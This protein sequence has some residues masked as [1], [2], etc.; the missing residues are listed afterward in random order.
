MHQSSDRWSRRRLL[1]S[2]AAGA[3]TLTHGRL[4][5]GAARPAPRLIGGL[6]SSVS[7]PG[8]AVAQRACHL[9]TPQIDTD[10]DWMP[11]T[12]ALVTAQEGNAL[13]F[14]LM[15]TPEREADWHWLAPLLVDRFVLVLAPG[16]Q[17]HGPLR[18]GALRGSFIGERLAE[19]GYLQV[20]FT[21]SEAVNARKLGLG[22][23][24][25]WATM[26]GVALAPPHLASLPAGFTLH[27]LALRPL[28][29]WLVASRDVAMAGLPHPGH[30]ALA[31][32]ESPAELPYRQL[33]T[34]ARS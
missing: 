8:S 22:R 2:A 6:V 26:Q 1:A 15:R 25:A 29:M 34:P 10:I 4:A 13:L 11:W 12:R 28:T 19:L 18:V 27:P 24:D 30:P 32:R 7:E 17:A 20:E 33:V 3:L 14:P 31:G 5:A 9:L 16:A 21:S 23:I